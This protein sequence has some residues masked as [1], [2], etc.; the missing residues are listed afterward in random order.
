MMSA[1][2][3][4]YNPVIP[5]VLRVDF[6]I[7]SGP[8]RFITV[9][10]GIRTIAQTCLAIELTP[11]FNKLRR[12]CY[13]TFYGALIDAYRRCLVRS[14]LK[15]GTKGSNLQ[16]RL[17]LVSEEVSLVSPFVKNARW[18]LLRVM[19]KVT[20]SKWRK[21]GLSMASIR[22]TPAVL[23]CK[24]CSD[25]YKIALETKGFQP[26][27]IQVLATHFVGIER[28][29][30]IV[31]AGPERVFSGVIVTS[32]RGADAWTN[33]VHKILELDSDDITNGAYSADASVLL[34]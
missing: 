5:L 1:D 18:P 19:P 25:T 3:P 2:A 17:R 21:R 22:T 8:S 26:Y 16:L 10:M 28:L 20:G 7:S 31:R 33:A 14:A 15:H 34:S 6:M 30:R 9:I 4:E 32:S 23:V 12:I 29:Q 11:D 27:F 24:E 13:K